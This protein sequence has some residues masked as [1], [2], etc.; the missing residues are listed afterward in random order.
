M[1]F[2]I[3][4]LLHDVA[5]RFS[6]LRAQRIR[7]RDSRVC[8]L[9]ECTRGHPKD[10]PKNKACVLTRTGPPFGFIIKPPASRRAVLASLF[11]GVLFGGGPSFFILKL[12]GPEHRPSLCADPLCI[13]YSPK[14]PFNLPV[15]KNGLKGENASLKDTK[16][17]P[18]SSAALMVS[19]PK[20]SLEIEMRLRLRLRKIQDP[21]G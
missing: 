9:G 1:I 21:A 11:F 13:A 12:V 14:S 19:A 17:A 4:F 5:L 18:A 20:T 8:F 3:V 15:E 7:Q 10:L 16:R 6:Y 2:F